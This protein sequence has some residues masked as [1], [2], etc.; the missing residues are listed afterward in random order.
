M[1]LRE[2]LRELIGAERFIIW[3]KMWF[4][5]CVTVLCLCGTSTSHR[6]Q[7]KETAHPTLDAPRGSASSRGSRRMHLP[8][9]L[10]VAEW[11][12]LAPWNA[13]SGNGTI[14]VV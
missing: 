1:G 6:V 12:F 7:Q 5:I 4:Y 10:S 14:H 11:L 13:V 2:S 9:V 3:E 8:G